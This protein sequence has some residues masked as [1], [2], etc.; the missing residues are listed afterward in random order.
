[1]TTLA[2]LKQELHGSVY[3]QGDT[4]RVMIASHPLRTERVTVYLLAGLSL[5]EI[6]D[7]ASIEVRIADLATAVVCYLDGHPVPRENWSNV[8]P[9]AGTTVFLRAVAEG[10]LVAGV[11]AIF[12]AVSAAARSAGGE[13][14]C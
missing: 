9:K 3:G 11:G 14:S 12:S 2:R 7:Q 8:R 10:P 6:V 4:V 1:M 5:A 13:P